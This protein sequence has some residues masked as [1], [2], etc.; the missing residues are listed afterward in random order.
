MTQTP[1]FK[2]Y[3]ESKTTLLEAAKK[4]PKATSTYNVRKYCKMV[5]GESKE[6]KDYVALKPKQKIHV[7]WLY[8][9]MEN[10]IPVSI[11]FENVD[12]I[13][14]DDEF[15]TFWE[16]SRFMKWLDKNSHEEF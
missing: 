3:I 11:Q 2:E 8:E 9:D 1:S 4:D 12:N 14:L 10:P 15:S 16:G 6:A 13:Q 5:V 7:T